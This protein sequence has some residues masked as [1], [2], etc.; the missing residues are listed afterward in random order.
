MA[1]FVEKADI[2]IKLMI[3]LL[4][5][6]EL[7]LN[8]WLIMFY[9][10]KRVLFNEIGRHIAFMPSIWMLQWFWNLAD[11][12]YAS[13]LYTFFKEGVLVQSRDYDIATILII[14]NIIIAKMHPYVFLKCRYTYIALFMQLIVLMST[15]GILIIFITHARWTEVGYASLYP[16]WNL[17][18]FYINFNWCRVERDFNKL[19]FCSFYPQSLPPAPSP[20]F[21]QW[22]SF[23]TTRRMSPSSLASRSCSSPTSFVVCSK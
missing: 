16:L 15:V 17:Y 18:L 22:Q 4:L 20:L 21:Q 14:T 7:Y 13:A 9:K 8:V 10:K 19:L 6:G 3:T 12:F 2:A 11:F 23:S 5:C 1:L